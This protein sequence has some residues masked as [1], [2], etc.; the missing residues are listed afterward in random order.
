[1]TRALLLVLASACTSLLPAATF[2]EFQRG[3]ANSDGVVNFVDVVRILEWG[4]LVGTPRLPCAAAID[5]D[6][7]G[8]IQP[9]SSAAQLIGW[10]FGGGRPP[11]VIGCAIQD[12]MGLSCETSGCP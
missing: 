6:A 11:P 2:P 8:V 10:L 3:D 5:L 9:I 4:F 7:D 1:M 12:P